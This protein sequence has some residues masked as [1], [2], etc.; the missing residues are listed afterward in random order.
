MTAMQTAALPALYSG[1][2][3][4]LHSLESTAVIT[5]P[6]IRIIRWQYAV[7]IWGS[8]SSTRTALL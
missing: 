4:T 7:E 6:F 2:F 8:T 3:N 1:P 5:S